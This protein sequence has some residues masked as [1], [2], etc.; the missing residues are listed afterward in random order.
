MI[1]RSE[2]TNKV[3][4]GEVYTTKLYIINLVLF[5][6]EKISQQQQQTEQKPHISP[7]VSTPHTISSQQIPCSTSQSQPQS[8]HPMDRDRPNDLRPPEPRIKQEREDPPPG[9]VQSVPVLRDVRDMRDVRDVRD[10]RDLRDIREPPPI[11]TSQDNKPWGYAGMD[12]MNTSNAFWQNYSGK[13][14]KY[15]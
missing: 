3:F 13:C 1:I 14:E 4:T 8:H 11:P 5:L 6:L 7:A 2:L 10:V 12:L 15:F 9:Y